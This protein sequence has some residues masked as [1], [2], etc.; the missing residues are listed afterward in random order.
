MFDPFERLS[1]CGSIGHGKSDRVARD[2]PM[3]DQILRKDDG[4]FTAHF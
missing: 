1:I 4:T 2:S 3:H